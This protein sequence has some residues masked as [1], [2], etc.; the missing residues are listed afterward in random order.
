MKFRIP[1]M[2]RQFFEKFAQIVIIIH[3]LAMIEE[4]HFISLVANGILITKHNYTYQNANNSII[5]LIFVRILLCKN[6]II[7]VLVEIVFF[8]DLF[9][10]INHVITIEQIYIL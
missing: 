3:L 6:I 1:I 7:R 10:D 9:K 2:H 5:N 8:Q 4:I